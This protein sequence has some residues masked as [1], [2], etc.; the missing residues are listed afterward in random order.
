MRLYGAGAMAR[1]RTIRQ[2][3][4]PSQRP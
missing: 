1:V 2:H 3:I 4:A